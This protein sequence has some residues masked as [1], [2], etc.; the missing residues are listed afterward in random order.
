MNDFI[1]HKI[2]EL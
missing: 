2:A 1:H